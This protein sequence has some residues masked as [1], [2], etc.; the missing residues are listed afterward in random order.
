MNS[1]KS[2]LLKIV[3]E[4]KKPIENYDFN[5]RHYKRNMRK[6]A[7]INVSTLYR[8]LSSIFEQI[9][10]L[11]AAVALENGFYT[12]QSDYQNLIRQ[13]CDDYQ[14]VVNIAASI[15][16]CLAQRSGLLGFLGDTVIRLRQC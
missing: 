1:F 11:K 14:D 6:I 12:D 10:E 2:L 16:I 3:T 7:Q 4:T 5:E 13:F 15:N 8:R 9:S